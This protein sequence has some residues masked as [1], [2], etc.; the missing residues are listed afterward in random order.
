MAKGVTFDYR[1]QYL[2]GVPVSALPEPLAQFSGS[3]AITNWNVTTTYKTLTTG[4]VGGQS[5]LFYGG[6][7]QDPTNGIIDIVLIP[8][9]TAAFT[10]QTARY[11]L[12]LTNLSNSVVTWLM[13]GAVNVVGSLP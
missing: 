13:Y 3:M 7:T 10:F 5:G 9:D 11:T 8:S 2:Q 12:G 6:S 1:F 4:A